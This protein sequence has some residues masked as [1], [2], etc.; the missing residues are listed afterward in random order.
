MINLYI[1]NDYL[2]NRKRITCIFLLFF[3]ILLVITLTSG[4]L[5][6]RKHRRILNIEQKV[7]NIKLDD[8]TPRD[9]NLKISELNS[10]KDDDTLFFN[11]LSKFFY[12]FHNNIRNIG[13]EISS[14]NERKNKLINILKTKKISLI[15]K[16]IKTNK[17]LKNGIIY[18]SQIYNQLPLTKNIKILK[19]TKNVFCNVSILLKTPIQNQKIYFKY[20]IGN[21]ELSKEYKFKIKH[22]NKLKII[23]FSVLLDLRELTKKLSIKKIE[24]L[25]LKLKAFVVKKYVNILKSDLNCLL[26]SE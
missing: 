21:Y 18:E 20:F 15:N 22:K 23:K 13:A 14:F 5:I 17:Y 3:I 8:V 12:N 2:I 7:D 6:F 4:L 9:Y 19:S 24:L 10:N 16:S 11:N 26:F 25:K 1:C